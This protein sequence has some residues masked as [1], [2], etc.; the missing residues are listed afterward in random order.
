MSR[1]YDVV[2]GT[3]G[4]GSGIFLAL[5]GNRTLGRE[6]SRPA[7]LLDQRDYCKLH[8]VCHY[9]RRLL[10]PDV[11]VV[12]IGKVGPDDA[13]RAV[14]REMRDT[15]LDTALVTRSVRPT[16]FSVCFLYPDGDGGNLSTSRSASADTGPADVQQAAPI[17]AAHPG[18]GVAL[19]LPEVPLD[20][21]ATLL[22]LATDHGWLR[23][24][25]FVPDE[26]QSV[27]DSG[28]LAHVDV[29]ALNIEEAATLAGISPA[30][31]PSEVVPAALQALAG[32]D[33][34]AQVVVTA[35]A[36]GSW[37]WDGHELAHASA[38]D[39]AGA[40]VSTAGAGDAHLAGIVV[41]LI[42]G[43]DIRAANGFAALVSAMKVRSAHTINPDI[44]PPAIVDTA[45][46]HGLALPAVLLELLA[47]STG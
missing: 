31:P 24:A 4:I 30:L 47:G 25:G 17:F 43:L 3:G 44:D 35:G 16:L 41:G 34:P 20:A 15:G 38:V 42:A 33:S 28:L 23:V 32:L 14:L 21:R 12:P 45:T 22:Q 9:I 18:R 6:E 11:P 36:R 40:V 13:G 27:R 29:L 37:S 26:L 46:R 2:V 5:E 19:A 39:V 8:I 7:E 10:G 1:R